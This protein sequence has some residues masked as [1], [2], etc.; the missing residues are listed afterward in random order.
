MLFG[1]D[2]QTYHLC[3][4]FY[5][6]IVE[7][8]GIPL[9]KKA[10]GNQGSCDAAGPYRRNS[11]RALGIRYVWIRDEK[12]DP[13]ALYAVAPADKVQVAK[14]D[15]G[16]ILTAHDS[17][18]PL[19]IKDIQKLLGMSQYVICHA[20][21]SGAEFVR[22]L[23]PWAADEYF[24]TNIRSR[25]MRNA[26]A[27]AVRALRGLI[28]HLPPLELAHH[29]HRVNF[30]YLDASGRRSP[31]ATNAAD[32]GPAAPPRMGGVIVT[33]TG[34]VKA[35]TFPLPD[36]HEAASYDIMTLETA[37]VRVAQRLYAADLA[38]AMAMV[39]VDNTVELFALIKLSSRQGRVCNAAN[40]V[41]IANRQNNARC[42]YRYTNTARNPA[43]AFSR[44]D[45]LQEAL[46][47]WRP[48]ELAQIKSMP[49]VADY[50]VAECKPLPP[51]DIFRDTS[52]LPFKP[53]R[54]STA[55]AA[56][57]RAWKE[58]HPA[59]TGT[60][61]LA[62]SDR[63]LWLLTMQTTEEEHAASGA[64]RA[65]SRPPDASRA[66][67]PREHEAGSQPAGRTRREK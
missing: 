15:C 40:R 37:T 44:K 39:S 8:L 53:D 43:D 30:L 36:A 19:L 24:N 13:T 41:A 45:L 10:A 9:S 7:A 48:D 27:T 4:D 59:L 17:K 32:R 2:P 26:L 22:H 21:R 25:Q 23:Y 50:V 54:D 5:I 49:D 47:F 18:Q 29:D 52:K 60:I 34:K 58:R 38:N 20:S 28:D 55:Q 57:H 12:G 56:R 35:F 62:L 33:H 64:D 63:D 66:K 67:R 16:K 3:R 65:N 31:D 51:D 1:V 6:A 11:V 61:I 42:W 46:N 14:E